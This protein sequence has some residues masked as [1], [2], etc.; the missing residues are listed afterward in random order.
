LSAEEPQHLGLLTCPNCK[1]EYVKIGLLNMG[2]TLGVDHIDVHCQICK[3]FINHMNVS[4]YVREIVS[5]E[6][7]QSS[8]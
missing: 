3:G 1:S 4:P 6:E 2:K 5:E 8:T 7:K